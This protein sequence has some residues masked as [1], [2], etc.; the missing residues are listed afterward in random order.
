LKVSKNWA[1]KIRK[2]SSSEVNIACSP[3]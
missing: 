1:A 2:F 3:P